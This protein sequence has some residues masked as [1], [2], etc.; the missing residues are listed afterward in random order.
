MDM[1]YLEILQHS[2]GA[3]ADREAEEVGGVFHP[4]NSAM[5]SSSSSR[6]QNSAVSI[7]STPARPQAA[8]Y[9]VIPPPIFAPTVAE[10][11]LIAYADCPAVRSIIR[12]PPLV[13][14]Q[15]LQP[16]RR[17]QN[18]GISDLTFSAAT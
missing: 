9:L 11:A 13:R 6:I 14:P 10:R 18:P 15:L 17:K 1:R 5:H 4:L 7:S 2:L 12:S 8:H 3:D 16:A